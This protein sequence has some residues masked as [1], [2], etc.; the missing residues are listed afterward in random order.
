MSEGFFQDCAHGRIDNNL[1]WDTCVVNIKMQLPGFLTMKMSCPCRYKACWPSNGQNLSFWRPGTCKPLPTA[2]GWIS[3][4]GNGS[5]SSPG[6]A[7]PAETPPPRISAPH[8]P[9]S[10]PTIVA[11]FKVPQPRNIYVF[12]TAW[13][14]CVPE[15]STAPV[16]FACKV[17]FPCGTHQS[18]E[19]PDK[20]F[21][22]LWGDAVLEG[23]GSQHGRWPP[24]EP[25]H[26]PFHSHWYGH[27][28]FPFCPFD[29][30]DYKSIHCGFEKSF[31]CSRT[32]ERAVRFVRLA[33]VSC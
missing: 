24:V 2:A 31:K 16:S 27:R 23:H 5:G 17:E 3:Q 29:E 15:A 19:A 12:R 9:V 7:P 14:S 11:T 10:Q 30:V 1:I 25:D 13:L 22:W 26:T 6:N 20:S 8:T 18:T 21:P 33:N 28:C 32:A 4:R